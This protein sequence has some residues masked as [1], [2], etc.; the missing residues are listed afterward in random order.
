VPRTHR[1]YYVPKDTGTAADNVSTASA[2]VGSGVE[3]G[4]APPSDEMKSGGDAQAKAAIELDGYKN[5]RA[6]TKGPDGLWHGRAMRG[7]TEIAV[8][9]DAGGSVSAE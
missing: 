5:V 1:T 3:G 9:V 7:R 2:V 4:L 8:R 6:L